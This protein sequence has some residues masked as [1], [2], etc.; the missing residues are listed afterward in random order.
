MATNESTIQ[1]LEEILGAIRLLKRYE[2][3][4]AHHISQQKRQIAWSNDGKH[5]HKSVKLL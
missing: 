1:E 3:T 5:H 4:L 2:K